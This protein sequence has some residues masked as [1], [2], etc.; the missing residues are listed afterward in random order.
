MI[1]IIII[2]VIIELLL[3]PCIIYASNTPSIFFV[4]TTGN[5]ANNGSLLQP[6]KTIQH[7][8]DLTRPGDT[9]YVEK[10]IYSPFLIKNKR[11]IKT[12]PIQFISNEAVID[13]RQSNARDGI[14]IKNSDYITIRGFT[15]KNANRSGISIIESDNINIINNQTTNNK[16]WG[17]FSGF[18]DHLLINNNI[19]SF[20]KR[21]HGIYVSNTCIN[22]IISNNKVFG[23]STSG[24]QLNG[25]KYMG[26]EGLIKYAKIYNNTIFNNGKK[27][28]AALNLDGVQHSKIYNNLLFDNYSTGIAVYK[29][30]GGDGSKYNQI[31]NNSIMMP[32]NS[33]WC[34]LFNN[35]SSNNTFINNMCINQ[36][37]Y[38]GSI[39]IDRTSIIGFKSNFNA[40]TPVF[41]LN[42]SD[43]TIKME[44]WRKL[45]GQDKNSITISNTSNLF[46][47]TLNNYKPKNN[48]LLI[49]KGSN[50]L[51]SQ[52]G[53]LGIKRNIPDIG[54]FESSTP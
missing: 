16:T 52:H 20:S 10:G 5:N 50:K 15:V 33:R 25:D 21:Q 23:N 47:N 48:N 42:H 6:W 39:N 3:F 8:S 38:K 45:T 49:N 22:P 46:N 43:S 35:T 28:G 17:I 13:G 54:A 19:A 12:A 36:H 11:G 41:S 44:K 4:I 53:I 29:D 7:A 1:N 24:I 9:I 26:Q 31:Y 51:Y 18:S 40:L 2:S 30:D 27:G 37:H 34:A 32:P 14:T